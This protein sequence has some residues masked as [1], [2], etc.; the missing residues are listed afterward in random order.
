MEG[1]SDRVSLRWGIHARPHEV[2]RPT[3]V[4]TSRLG[5][6]GPTR[7]AVEA[8]PIAR[9]MLTSAETTHLDAVESNIAAD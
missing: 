7:R 2:L 4:L 1:W 3:P 6:D 8:I 9:A 5:G